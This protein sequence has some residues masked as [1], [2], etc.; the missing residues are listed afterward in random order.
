LVSLILASSTPAA[1]FSVV[2][3]TNYHKIELPKGAVGPESVAFDCSGK[4]P[5]VGVSDGRILKWQGPLWGW[6]EYA[7]TSPTRQREICDGSTDNM[8][9]PTCGRP[10]GLKFNPKT[11][12]LYIADAYFG[13]LKID[14]NGGHPQQLAT[15]LHE[16]P[17]RFTNALDI[18]S[19]TGIVYFTDTSTVYQRRQRKICDR[20]TDN[21]T[22]PICGRP[23]GLK[24]HPKTCELYIADAYFGILK[25]GR[26]GGHP[27]QLA[28]S[29]N[30][31]PFRF[32]NALEIDSHTGIVYF[33]DTSTIFQRRFWPLSIATGDKTGRLLQYDPCTKKVT[34]LLDKLAFANGVALSKDSSFLLVAES[35]TSKIFKLWL[36]GP[37]AGDVELFTQLKRPADNI[38]RTDNGEFWVA[39]NSR[40]ALQG[41]QTSSAFWLTKDPVGVKFDEQGNIVKVLDGEGGPTLESVSEVEEHNGKLWIGSV[42]KPYVG[43]LRLVSTL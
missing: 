10:L 37:N 21:A 39:L 40:R 19:E 20:S 15:S 28:T 34:V 2:D 24:F 14:R 33:T 8:T 4:G 18:D 36:R 26:N 29:L 12:E 16:V 11:C 5:Y 3:L 9:E 42:V 13:L 38:K 25:I 30:G 35:A 22:E 17:F 6:T 7:F 32:T 31:V 43:V 41:N 27:Q 1:T 23:L